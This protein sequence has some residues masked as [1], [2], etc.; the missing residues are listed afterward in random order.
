MPA[1]AEA[2]LIV[3]IASQFDPHADSVIDQFHTQ[4]FSD[5]M[6]IDLGQVHLS[7]KVNFGPD[8]DDCFISDLRS[9]RTA[10]LSEIGAVWWRRSDSMRDAAFE[11]DAS[12]ETADMNEAAINTKSIIESL[13]EDRF[14]FGHPLSMRRAENKFRGLQ[15]AAEAGFSI[16]P[17]L[18]STST[19]EM[20]KFARSLPKELVIKPT[21]VR[22]V[23]GPDGRRALYVKAVKPSEFIDAVAGKDTALF[24]QERVERLHDVRAFIGEDF[25]FAAEIS[26]ESLPPGECDWRPFTLDCHHRPTN[27]PPQVLQ[28]ARSYL[29]K[30]GLRAAHFDFIVD[31]EEIFFFMEAN[32]NGQWMWLHYKCG[33]A[34]PQFIANRLI[35]CHAKV[36]ER[37]SPNERV[38]GARTTR[39][40]IEPSLDTGG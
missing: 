24:L 23:D 4:G 12:T 39:D 1:H 3:I 22:S 15:A 29:T 20:V 33:L 25:S 18:F 38:F 28:R 16:P 5:F 21:G 17:Y 32:S 26:V 30:M 35:E 14:P 8:A 7:H 31:R 27:L 11:L 9:G 2:N 13:A 19:G 6:R 40:A 34:I 37:T 36:F 10:Q